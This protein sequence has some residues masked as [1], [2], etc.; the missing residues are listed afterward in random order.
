MI[1]SFFNIS[2]DPDFARVW[3]DFTR[4]FAF[5]GFAAITVL[6]C[7][8]SVFSQTPTRNVLFLILAFCGASG[9]MVLRGA[10]F[11]A[12]TVLIVYVGAVAALFLFVVMMMDLRLW[13]PLAKFTRIYAC[14][15]V[16]FAALLL[17]S[18][19]SALSESPVLIDDAL[20]I[21]RS[22]ETISNTRAIGLSLY[23]DRALPFF[24]SGMVLL[25]AM[26][27]A[28]SLTLRSR[29][30]VKRQSIDAQTQTKVSDRL[31]MT[32]PETGKGIAS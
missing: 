2:V 14:A 3:S 32:R 8:G 27:A 15:G 23:T 17:I 21:A 28:V 24:G 11:L 26:V 1:E 12:M 22:S 4:A 20:R 13:K 6:S 7:L 18:V 29:D 16:A 25:T 10:E 19:L 30:G 31:T 9:L 5:Y